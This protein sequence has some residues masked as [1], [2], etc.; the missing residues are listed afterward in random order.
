LSDQGLFQSGR[1]VHLAAPSSDSLEKTVNFY[2]NDVI[3]GLSNS[4]VETFDESLLL[5]I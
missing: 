2:E 3:E 4:A 1:N 5:T